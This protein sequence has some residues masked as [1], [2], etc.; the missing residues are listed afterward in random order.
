MGL[1]F[2]IAAGPRQRSHSQVRV[3]RDSWPNYSDSDSRLPQSGGPG[4]RIYIPQE[5][6]DPV[7]PPGTGFPFR[8]LQ[9][10]AGIQWRYSTSPPHESS[11]MLRP[12]VSRPVCLGIKYPSGAYS[13]AVTGLLMWGAL[14]DERTGPS[15]TIAAGLRQRNHSRVRVLWDWRS[16]FTASDLKLPV[17]SPPTTRRA[18]MEIFYPAST[19][20]R[21][22]TGSPPHVTTYCYVNT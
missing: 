14:S 8:R 12:T 3:S 1:L 16:Y 5:Q 13:Q 11:L 15:F 2:T 7:I 20:D 10:L 22:H 9:R 19:R 4:P 6:G 18:T 21:L 17:F